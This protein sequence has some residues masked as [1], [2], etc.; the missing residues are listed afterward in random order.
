MRVSYSALLLSSL[1]YSG[2]AAS[3]PIDLLN[4]YNLIVFNDLDS[5]SA[6]EGHT[7]VI[8]NLNGTAS[9]YG[10]GSAPAG[11]SHPALVIGGD[12]N[13]TVQIENGHNA[14]LG[15]V[16]NGAINFNGSG[17]SLTTD[18][19]GYNF[20]QIQ[21][22]LTAYSAYLASLSSNS[23]LSTPSSCCGNALFNVNNTVGSSESVFAISAS[24]L[25]ENPYVQAYDIDFQGQNPYAVIIN[26]A[27][28]H[29]DDAAFTAN[30]IG[31][32]TNSAILDVIIW[33]FY[34]AETINLTRQLGGHL[35][36]P[37]ATL[38]H[39]SNLK[40]AVVVNNLIQR[41]LIQQPYDDSFPPVSGSYPVPAPTTLPLLLIGIG[42]TLW[43]QRRPRRPSP[44]HAIAA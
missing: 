6:V 27:G 9:N 35:L 36:A 2:L 21:T 10:T 22:D 34:E 31:N 25:F 12:L 8:G 42:G 26:V 1:L 29:I 20:Q 5:Q 28:S 33:N 17:G 14:V 37:L 44:A 30:P 7:L 15:G 41:A 3:G 24:T 38:T 4:E 13:A 18:T 39:A 19:S 23:L 32:F 40:G 43:C 11:G 16:N